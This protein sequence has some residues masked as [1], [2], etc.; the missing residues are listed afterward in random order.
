ME[1]LVQDYGISP[2]FPNFHQLGSAASV[3]VSLMILPSFS[4][5]DWIYG[6]LPGAWLRISASGSVSSGMKVL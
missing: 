5:V 4:L 2:K 6:A 3:D 1:G